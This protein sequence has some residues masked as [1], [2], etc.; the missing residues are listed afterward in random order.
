MSNADTLARA[1]ACRPVAVRVDVSKTSVRDRLRPTTGDN[2]NNKWCIAHLG[3][4]MLT[5]PCLA[6]VRA[7]KATGNAFKI[8]PLGRKDFRTNTEVNIT[9]RIICESCLRVKGNKIANHRHRKNAEHCKTGS[10]CNS[11][12]KEEWPN[13]ALSPKRRECP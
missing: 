7:I 2:E 13:H 9:T 4:E 12:M 5:A 8:A 6:V 3:N 10:T 11:I 1:R